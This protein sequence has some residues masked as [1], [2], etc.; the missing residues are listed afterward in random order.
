MGLQD[1]SSVLGDK[2]ELCL[3][4]I[5]NLNNSAFYTFTNYYN[6]QKRINNP[7]YQ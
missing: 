7:S 6:G 4:M 3:K 1:S 5:K 2:I